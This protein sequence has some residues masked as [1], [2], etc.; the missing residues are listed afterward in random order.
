MSED[1]YEMTI[2]DSVPYTAYG[3]TIEYGV[4]IRVETDNLHLLNYFNTVL[5]E[6]LSEKNY[7]KMWEEE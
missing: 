2:R 4:R 6:L 5:H 3:R 7:Y 1:N